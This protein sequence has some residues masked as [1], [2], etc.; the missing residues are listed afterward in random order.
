MFCDLVGSTALSARLDPEDM[1]EIIGAYHRCCAEQIIKAGGFVAKYM[2]DWVLAYFG[3][4]Q[5]HED[6]A[7]RAVQASLALIE[8]VPKLRAQH[9]LQVRIGVATGLVVVGDLVG[10]G[11]AQEHGVVGDTPNLA[12]RLQ[13]LAEPGEVV[14]S[15]S[16]RRL[17][18]GMFEYRD[19][20][21]VALKGLSE[22]VQAWQVTGSSDVQSRFEARLHE[23]SLTTLVGR[24]EE[25]ELLLRRWERA[26]SGQGQVVLLSGE[27]G[28]GKS[29]LT[30]ALR[31]RLEGEPHVG[32][33]Y[34]CSPHHTDSAFY[35][36]VSELERSAGFQRHDA[37]DVRLDKLRTLLG[38]PADHERDCQLLADFLSIPTGDRYSPLDWS[39]Q[40]KK[41]ETAKAL[42]THLETL[43]QQGP[44]L[45]IYEDAQW[46]DPSTRELL[47][48]T[49]QRVAELPVLLIV[50]FRPEFQPAWISEAHFTTLKLRRLG[51]DEGSAL[52]ERVAGSTVLP[53]N[54]IAVIV[55]R[56][57]GVPLF[58]EELTKAVLE[59]RPHDEEAARSLSTGSLDA[60]AVPITLHASLMARLDRL[61]PVARE[62][63]QVGAAIGREFSYELIAAVADR[64][65][66]ALR[67]A[68]D[69]LVHAGL[70]FRRGSPPEATFR[71]KHA[72][73]Q[74]AAHS[75]LLRSSRQ[76]LHAQIA[77]ALEAHSPELVDSQPELF[78]QHYAEAGFVEKSVACWGKAG[79][80][81]VARA[82]IVEAAAQFR[83]GLDQLALLPDSPERQ[84]QELEFCNSLSAALR[85]VKGQGAPETGHTYARARELW[86]RLG[87][88][89]EF[90]QIPYGQS[91]YHAHRGELDLAHLLD[92]DLLR[93]SRQRN[94]VA[95][96]ILGHLS[97]GVNLM[98]AGVFGSSRSHL[99]TAPALYDPISHRPLLQQAGVHPHVFSQAYLGNVLFCLGFPDQALALSDANIAE[100]RRL[101]HP[102]SLAGGLAI[103]AR[104]L[105]LIGDDAM[106]DEWVSQL[107]AVATEQGF[108]HWRTQGEIYRG[109]VKVR[110]GDAAKG[111]SKLRSGST[112]YRAG[113]V[114]LFVPHYI[115][116]LAAACEVAAQVEEGLI[117]L[118]DAL[119]IVERTRERW[120]AAEL[121]RH[122]GQLRLRQGHSEAADALYRT[123][124]GIA[125][126]QGA[127]LWEL[128]AST[129]L[130]RLWRAQG[131]RTEAR[132]LLAPIYGWFTE[133]FDTPD[134]KE[135]KALLEELS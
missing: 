57:D 54:V 14:I 16:T 4:L 72:L 131:K 21:R 115:D 13:G 85:A 119:Q 60:L 42:L 77:A 2:G 135:A 91:R 108:P 53:D 86:E 133:G 12:A 80:R 90:V 22:P 123:A 48:A 46:I 83:K 59:A 58:V 75:S 106:L 32:Q 44:V 45:M 117:L 28:I 47:D 122:K 118:D 105:S 112:A 100:A 71:F 93:L 63:A 69:Q 10:E 8:A 29:R 55:E 132:E 50:T 17:T 31:E 76:K 74:D 23:T 35:P 84:R 134:L 41:N 104:L 124:L 61:G 88:P 26:K 3:Y 5:A 64:S 101:A 78:A 113:G 40:R 15:N 24:E 67:A 25:A 96:L 65:D 70:V 11:V 87:S 126:E 95:G 114:E 102:P 9:A 37:A 82:A 110:S 1:R 7:E 68:L 98:F 39:P 128:R 81:S 43:C 52:V 51:Q 38:S 97:S 94:D 103:G 89:R 18:G 116:L 92:E 109:W 127:K 30:V 56:T 121:N 79:H 111:M 120:F 129:S 27:P 62:S 99:E 130:A 49:L 6:D 33:Q 19:L 107:L 66:E 125:Q 20:G 73:L 34:F 36:I